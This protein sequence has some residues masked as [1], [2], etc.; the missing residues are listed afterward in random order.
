MT[1]KELLLGYKSI[2]DTA[3]HLN[4]LFMEGMAQL[5]RNI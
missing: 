4:I 3:V 1:I 5:V 2:F